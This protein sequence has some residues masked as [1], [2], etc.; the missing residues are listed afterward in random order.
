LLA[1][2]GWLIA[3]DYARAQ[4]GLAQM[5][6]QLAD[7][8]QQKEAE[9]RE[10]FVRLADLE[11][12]RAVAAERARILRDMHDGVGTHLTSAIRQLQSGL[13]APGAVEQ[14]LRDSLDQLK[15]SIDALTM[16]EG[17]VAGLLGGLRFR[18]APRLE[19]AGLALHWQVDQLPAWPEGRTEAMRHVQYI[20]FEAI[21]NV[22]QHSGATA[23][24]IR[25][26]HE[27]ASET[28]PAG[29]IVLRV[30]DNGRGCPAPS[31][32]NGLRGMRTRARAI[33][34]DLVVGPYGDGT[35]GCEVMLRLPL[36]PPPL[37]LSAR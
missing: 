23:I 5:N 22:L 35:S 27:A 13:A 4:Q 17:D 24:A 20:V 15:L 21:S 28:T 9:L 18:L 2:I 16:E 6:Q 32:R 1:A 10:S 36:T 14:T 37:A 31:E 25:A 30:Q 7:R 26:T 29:V 12:A 33:H 34:A 11:R 3:G 19:A 8:V